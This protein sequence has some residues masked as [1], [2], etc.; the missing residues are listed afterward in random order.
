MK[1][2]VYGTSCCGTNSIGVLCTLLFY[3]Q[4]LLTAAQT[5]QV[6]ANSQPMDDCNIT[7]LQQEREQMLNEFFQA[8]ASIGQYAN[9]TRQIDFLKNI[10][11]PNADLVLN[12]VGYYN[13]SSVSFFLSLLD[14]IEMTPIQCNN[15]L[16][17]NLSTKL[18]QDYLEYTHLSNPVFNG[19]SVRIV[20][21]N[22]TNIS[23]I[24]DNQINVT[25]SETWMDPQSDKSLATTAN[26]MIK[27]VPCSTKILLEQVAASNAIQFIRDS[28]QGKMTPTNLC[29]L[30]AK[31]CPNE[32]F[33]FQDVEQCLTFISSIPLSC[34]DGQHALQGNTTS[35]RYLH[36]IAA[37]LDPVTHCSHVS[38]QSV[39]C[40]DSICAAGK[41]SAI[42]MAD[43]G[44]AV[45]PAAWS[46]GAQLAC[47]IV[48]F[49]IFCIP[50]LA[51]IVIWV[52][53]LR[54]FNEP[55]PIVSATAS[56]TFLFMN[57]MSTRKFTSLDLEIKS[58]NYKVKN[59]PALQN[60][61]MM[62]RAGHLHVVMG[63][64][65]AGKST[66]LS[67][68]AQ[69]RW[70]RIT[71]G[72]VHVIKG[73]SGEI[74]DNKEA[75]MAVRL[76]KQ[77]PKDVAGANPVLTVKES[78]ILTAMSTVRH[79]EGENSDEYIQNLAND[80]IYE[81]SL[82]A[83]AN[84]ALCNL[85]GG[86][87]K[88]WDIA[89]RLVERPS[90]LLADEPTSGLDASSA[91]TVMS[92]LKCL[93]D[94]GRLVIITLHQPRM[95]IL[96]MIDDVLLLRA[97]GI[98]VYSGP[99]RDLEEVL[100]SWNASISDSFSTIFN[101]SIWSTNA[102][103]AVTA[104]FREL[105]VARTGK[106]TCKGLAKY[107]ELDSDGYG[108]R[109]EEWKCTLNHVFAEA[110]DGVSLLQLADWM[111]GALEGEK[112]PFN[113]QSLI[114]MLEEKSF[115]DPEEVPS[116]PRALLQVL[117]AKSS[118]DGLSTISRLPVLQND[119]PGDA[120]ADLCDCPAI[121]LRLNP[122][123]KLNS[124]FVH[125][126]VK[127]MSTQKADRKAQLGKRVWWRI[128]SADAIRSMKGNR[129]SSLISYPMGCLI[130]SLLLCL[131]FPRLVPDDIHSIYLYPASLL[132]ALS[133][134]TNLNVFNLSWVMVRKQLALQE[135]MLQESST[136]PLFLLWSLFS[137]ASFMNWIGT[138][139]FCLPF[140]FVVNFYYDRVIAVSFLLSLLSI[141]VFSGIVS[142][143]A[144]ACNFFLSETGTALVMGLWL[145]W[146]ALF[147]GVL[148]KI[149][150]LFVIFYP[151]AAYVAPFWHVINIWL[152]A[153][154]THE[155]TVCGP[156]DQPLLCPP[157]GSDAL[158]SL[159]Y[160]GVSWEVSL[161][162]LV[163]TLVVYYAIF[164]TILRLKFRNTYGNQVMPGMNSSRR[165]GNEKE[166]LKVVVEL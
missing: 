45:L 88:R 66:L 84:T 103:N 5:D 90:V 78:I 50:A 100:G 36:A 4:I 162:V 130:V 14:F 129:I 114:K 13:G 70:G 27:F 1:I 65:G 44:P 99:C 117:E 33:P 52:A 149:D 80:A 17:A 136:R 97:G 127:R 34:N 145:S 49:V 102:A 105:D 92:S 111:R 79:Q 87:S 41:Y 108:W 148:V 55:S 28:S 165:V 6:V 133:A 20:S 72:H 56:R 51:Y 140:Y 115:S 157:T 118:D 120:M 95:S 121:D 139:L 12:G 94:S 15:R 137:R 29:S 166:S 83:A 156:Y 37:Q 96:N 76:V 81:M 110:P 53:G 74:L 43:S 119:T 47:F 112:M 85:S 89:T 150:E 144:D 64:S 154:F 57:R 75:S 40:Y 22:I 104:I 46:T 31:A 116:W 151:W 146:N 128:L 106:I 21:R 158:V 35:C 86:Q 153:L 63:T 147:A 82:E 8:S 93:A 134:L 155:E 18:Q 160:G 135:Q 143:V 11:D 7:M 9:I 25:L 163:G 26:E 141:V 164:Y 98:P 16:I 42:T 142:A 48:I 125:F 24:S 71:S 159:G 38:I 60:V 23:W 107:F 61:S 161:F 138:I 77:C 62:A 113:K 2:R 10:I 59:R 67:V 124:E 123:L 131:M 54:F 58:L 126:S 3:F 132:V 39:K 69:Q 101:P 32:L 109:D 152:T 30:I 68:I 122:S 19:N 73:R 91:L